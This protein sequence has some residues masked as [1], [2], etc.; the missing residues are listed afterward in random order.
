[1][2]LEFP[3]DTPGWESEADQET[4]QWT[5][6]P[7][8]RKCLK[9]SNFTDAQKAFIIKQTEDGKS[10]AEVCPISM[11]ALGPIE[12]ALRY[13]VWLPARCCLESAENPKRSTALRFQ[14]AGPSDWCSRPTYAPSRA[15]T[16]Q[17][18]TVTFDR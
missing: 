2:K 8:N 18:P 17:L 11:Q 9:A 1:M 15:R 10:V 14:I 5:V 3:E 4:V 6:F 16:C 12:G 7:L 13:S